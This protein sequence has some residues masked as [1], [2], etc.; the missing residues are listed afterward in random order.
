MAACALTQAL[1]RYARGTDC[2]NE[3]KT[4]KRRRENN[5]KK[6]SQLIGLFVNT[7]K[8]ENQLLGRGP[9]SCCCGRFPTDRTR[10]IATFRQASQGN[11][12]GVRSAVAAA[13]RQ[14]PRS[15]SVP[16]PATSNRQVCAPLFIVLPAATNPNLGYLTICFRI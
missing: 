3:E 5:N 4:E 2:E 7:R 10:K 9:S 11:L 8:R 15:S 13:L 6:L 16:S 12:V 1:P 14:L